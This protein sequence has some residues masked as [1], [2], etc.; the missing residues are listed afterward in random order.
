[1]NE[2]ENKILK[3]LLIICFRG[4]I[5]EQINIQ[6]SQWCILIKNTFQIIPLALFSNLILSSSPVSESTWAPGAAAA[7]FWASSKNPW[8]LRSTCFN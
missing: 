6:K 7:K 3:S 5:F 4:R 2:H 1:M 8:V